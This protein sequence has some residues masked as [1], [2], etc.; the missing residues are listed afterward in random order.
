VKV[1]VI[2]AGIVGCA[3]GY[4]LAAR[5]AGVRLLDMRDVGQGATRASAGV[6]CPHI[7]GHDAALLQLGTRSL[8]MYDEFVAHASHYS[9]QPIEY[10]RTGTL[11]V[12]L[13][14]EEASRLAALVSRHTSGGVE[15][16]FLDAHQA[17]HLEPQ[18]SDRVCGALL[19]PIHG[20]VAVTNFTEAL[21][22]A[23]ITRGATIDTGV[24]V[25]QVAAIGHGV[26]V[27][28]DRDVL[29]ADA[30]IVAA[31]S[32]SAS[33]G[34]GPS[35]P[36]VKPIRGQLLQLA[37]AKPPASR[38]V[39][40]SGCYLVPWED[41]S[42]LVGATVEDVGFDERSTPEG[43]QGLMDCA[44]ELMPSARSAQLAEVRVGLRPATS[45][46]LPI[47][48]PSSTV[49]GVFFA[50]GHYRNG[51]LLAPFTAHAVADMVLEHRTAP[52]LSLTRPRRFGL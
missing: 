15:H 38:V 17:R 1:I 24:K 14:D 34:I 43:V 4:E 47:I 16:Q 6:L 27:T 21:A 41:G 9:R 19:V 29:D 44:S 23:A 46:D 30:V 33:I 37:F 52:E 3:V 36:P 10:R 25:R 40:G 32:W 11:E 7:E 12:A 42:L 50:T 31:G 35:H 5:G 20:Y 45:D 8:A 28:T 49:A 39:W 22:A 13:T 26:R 51:V 18:L 2:G 48:G